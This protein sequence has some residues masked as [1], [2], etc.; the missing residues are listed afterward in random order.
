[1]S[2]KNDSHH[3][4]QVLLDADAV[5]VAAADKF[6]TEDETDET[7]SALRQAALEF[8]DAWRACEGGKG[9]P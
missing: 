8:S 4:A 6:G 1:M 3:P 9:R 7:R 2:K 5:L